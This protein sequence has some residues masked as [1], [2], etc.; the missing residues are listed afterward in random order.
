MES[1][2]LISAI[3]IQFSIIKTIVNVSEY[4]ITQQNEL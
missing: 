4:L 3:D 1:D 2:L